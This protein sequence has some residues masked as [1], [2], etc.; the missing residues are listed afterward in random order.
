MHAGRT[1]R[2]LP[3]LLL[4]AL[5]T[6]P[7][8]CA[9]LEGWL[10]RP[11]V[12]LAGVGLDDIGLS[13]ATLRFDVEVQNP[14]SVPL[15]LVN[16]D[17]G[18]AS[19][20]AAFLSGKADLQGT[21]PAEG[22]K[23]VS[24]PAKITYAKLLEA[25]SGVR[26]GAVVPYEAELGLSVK[27]PG[28]G[29]LRLPMKKS[30]QLPVPAAPEVSI[31]EIRWGRLTLDD[32]GGT[33]K[34]HLVNRN[35]FAMSLSRLAAALSLGGVEVARSA[36]AGQTGLA[37]GQAGDV[38]LPISLSPRKLGL[39]VFRML[40]GADA[41]YDLTGDAQVVTPFGPMTLPLTGSGKTL[42]RQ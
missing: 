9:A 37:A 41:S 18:L 29:D 26:P 20:G 30:G 24:L 35:Q 8:G 13:S 5:C 15:P 4:G 36:A 27:P 14:Y 25:L 10:K 1:L 19:R 7:G 34:L 22:K 6:M 21:V 11:T 28:L 2:T 42:L 3:A 17:Y 23:T 39:S 33:I 31:T 38:E 12:S 16:M 32:A 40:T